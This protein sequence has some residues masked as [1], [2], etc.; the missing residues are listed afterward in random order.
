LIDDDSRFRPPKKI[1]NEQFS[2][3][4]S[5]DLRL[6]PSALLALT[7]L[8]MP[9]LLSIAELK[10]AT[11]LHSPQSAIIHAQIER[12]LLKEAS[13]GKPFYEL[14]L[15]DASESMTLRAWADTEAYEACASCQKGEFIAIEGLFSHNAS[16]GLDARG[17]ELRLLPEEAIESLLEGSIERR[18]IL[19]TCWQTMRNAIETINDPRLLAL[20]EQFSEQ[21]GARF[22]RAAAARG[23]HHA[24]RGGLLEHSSHMMEAALALCGVYRELNR[25]LLIA[26]VLFHDIGKLWETCPPERG[27]GI[28]PELRGELLGHL[29]IGIEVINALWREL[30]KEGWEAHTPPSEEVRLHL[31]HLVAAH[32][33]QLEFG[34]PVLPKTP[35]AILLHFI[36]NIDARL[37]MF[38]AAYQSA[39]LGEGDLKGSLEWVKPLGVAPVFPLMLHLP[40][41]T[42]EE[43]ASKENNLLF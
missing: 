31:L 10:K 8:S 21:Y 3:I 4:L 43:K 38:S 35:E 41:V 24:R 18:L 9:S 40:P 16:F 29:S 33:G 39:S 27:F 22:R 17:W 34:S 1:N 6:H 30:P 11:R 5:P 2:P 26:G 28:E 32:H 7:L 42:P 19:D 15:R 25:D 13:N 23:N 20:C 14:F 36:D 12:L 37:E